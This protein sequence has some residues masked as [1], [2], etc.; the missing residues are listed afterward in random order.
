MVSQNEH[1][2]PTVKIS[3]NFAFFRMLLSLKEIAAKKFKYIK[4]LK[5]S[6]MGWLVSDTLYIQIFIHRMQKSTVMLHYLVFT[7][8]LE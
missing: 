3:Q 6:E 7:N 8:E 1:P 2:A 5:K 4:Y